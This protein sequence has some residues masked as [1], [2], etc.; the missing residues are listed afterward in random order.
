M[1]GRFP[2]K[3]SPSNEWSYPS[4]SPLNLHIPSLSIAPMALRLFV[5]SDRGI[6]RGTAE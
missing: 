1:I 4:I 3:L 5:K 2:E 6:S